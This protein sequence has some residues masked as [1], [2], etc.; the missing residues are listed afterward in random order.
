VSAEAPAAPTLRFLHASDVHVDDRPGGERGLVQLVDAALATEV[1]LVVLV[2][3]TFDNNRVA[4]A[5]VSLAVDALA[6]LAV[7]VVVLPGNHDPV[8]DGSVYDRVDLPD[9]VH[10]IRSPEGATFELAA[11]GLEL[12]GRAHHAYDDNRPLADVPPRGTQPWQVALA[13]GHLVRRPDDRHRS[14]LI[15]SEEIAASDR[16]Y[17]ALGHWDVQQDVSAGPVTAWYSGSPTRYAVTAL[18][19][20]SD[21]SGG[22]SVDV[23]SVALPG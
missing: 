10:V 2:G 6:R 21:G 15:T 17:V 20:L 22:R 8:M 9:H 5:T 23:A 11:L 1:D 13:H 19:T 4:P 14:Y 16:D 3:D 18:V 12:W 7:P